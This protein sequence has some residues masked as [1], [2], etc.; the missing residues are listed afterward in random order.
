[1]L[2]TLQTLIVLLTVIGMVA[3]VARR[4]QIPPAILLVVAGL[5]LAFLPEL[6]TIQLSPQLV[7]LVVLP[8]VVYWSAVTMS[9]RE[10]RSNLRPISLL[11]VGCVAFTTATTASAAHYFLGFPWAVAFV[12]GAIVSPPDEVAPLS[13]ARRLRLPSR[14]QVILEGE[15][16]ANDATSL[17]LYRFAV[18][19]VATGAFSLAQAGAE[20]VAIV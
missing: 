15:G 18:A 8:P 6:P 12:L 11:A 10:F 19:A 16:L 3:V 4:I 1:M 2:V 7:L 5:F 17:V 13:I 14:L 20:F 9:W